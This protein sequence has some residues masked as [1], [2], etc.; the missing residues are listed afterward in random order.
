[1]QPTVGIVCV[2][3]DEQPYILEFIE[4]HQKIGV[5]HF[6]IYDNDDEI[7]QQSSLGLKNI[8]QHF[9]NISIYPIH[10]Y[11]PQIHAY[12]NFFAEVLPTAQQD[13]Y[14]FIDIDEFICPTKHKTLQNF[15]I[16]YG[17]LEAIGIQC[18]IFSAN[19][20]VHPP[21]SNNLRT[22]YLRS[23]FDSHVKT[24]AHKS[25]LK[26]P[27][28]YNTPNTP[29]TQISYCVHNIGYICKDLN[30]NHL[31]NSRSF[32]DVTDIIC[33]N[34]Y[35]TKSWVE[36]KTRHLQRAGRFKEHQR[37]LK[38][39]EILS[40]DLSE[41]YAITSF[42]EKGEEST[43]QIELYNEYE[44]VC[45]INGL[46]T[47]VDLDTYVEKLMENRIHKAFAQLFYSI[48]ASLSLASDDLNPELRL[49]RL[50]TFT[51]R[52]SPIYNILVLDNNTSLFP[53]IA[54][55]AN[56]QT[57]VF[58]V[59]EL[60]TQLLSLYNATYPQRFR[61]I[62]DIKDSIHLTILGTPFLLKNPNCL[63]FVLTFC[64][65]ILIEKINYEKYVSQT[66]Q[67]A[68]STKMELDYWLYMSKNTT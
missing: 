39:S 25:V 44:T 42:V 5:S 53:S 63:N 49:R 24:L 32:Y 60:T 41:D 13:W 61:I 14:A 40:F 52:T 15:L 23:R 3:R 36:C 62:S 28:I 6:Y 54:L 34:H 48:T 29:Y 46:L 1:M 68:L 65:N 57:T 21:K 38:I 66:C 47:Q 64:D 33:Y 35:I 19:G 43:Q 51:L 9:T 18:R 27:L 7:I 37:D 4:H 31:S 30:G 26:T 20:H 10:A 22:S 59:E 12:L 45:H 11:Q 55:G 67:S 2:A 17:H 58:L 50:L 56:K 8:L 16:E